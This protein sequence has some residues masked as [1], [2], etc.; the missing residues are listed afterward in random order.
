VSRRR[1]LGVRLIDRPE[2][3]AALAHM[4]E[5]SDRDLDKDWDSTAALRAL[6]DSS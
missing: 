3:Q 4:Q 2:V 5:L 6:R 1:K